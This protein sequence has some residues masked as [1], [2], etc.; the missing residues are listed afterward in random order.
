MYSIYRNHY[1]VSVVE[2]E[3][4]ELKFAPQKGQQWVTLSARSNCSQDAVDMNLLRYVHTG[5]HGARTQDMFVFSLL[6]GKTQSPSQHFHI[7]IKD[8]EKGT[9]QLILDSEHRF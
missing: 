3:S 2:R 1:Y 5:L 9:K 7:S 8:L 4:L 6:D